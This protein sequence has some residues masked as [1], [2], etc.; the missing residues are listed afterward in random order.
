M[1]FF[2]HSTPNFFLLYI[3]KVVHYTYFVCECVCALAEVVRPGDN[4]LYLLSLL[5]TLV[6]IFYILIM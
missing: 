2:S 3:F 6:Y 4:C 5:V 1:T